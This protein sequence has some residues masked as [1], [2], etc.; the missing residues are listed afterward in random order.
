MVGSIAHI[1]IETFIDWRHEESPRKS[2]IDLKWP[3]KILID[4]KLNNG[5]AGV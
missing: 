1:Y 2:F 5:I 3:K 4:G